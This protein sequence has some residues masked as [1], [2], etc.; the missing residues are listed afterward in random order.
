MIVLKKNLT[1]K[2]SAIKGFYNQDMFLY[3]KK[4]LKQ[5]LIIFLGW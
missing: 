5:A 3:W 4:Y 1:A 2:T